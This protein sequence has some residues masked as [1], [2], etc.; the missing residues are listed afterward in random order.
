[1]APKLTQRSAVEYDTILYGNMTPSMAAGYLREGRICSRSFSETLAQMY[2]G[3]DLIQKL[4]DFYMGLG[5]GESLSSTKAKLRNWMTGRHHPG[6]REDYFRIAFALAFSEEQLNLLL[7]IC[8]DY[9]VQY[10]D[11][12]E[13]VLTWFLKRGG[14]YQEALHFLEAVQ[15]PLAEPAS[16]APEASLS[17]DMQ[18]TREI[19]LGLSAVSTIS[20]LR[21]F[22]LKNRGRFGRMHLR[23]YYYFEQYL[24]R[25]IRPDSFVGADEP[26]YTIERVMRTYLSLHMPS[27][28]NRAN[29]SLVQKLIKQ[30]WPNVTSLK[31]ICN[32]EMEVPRKLLL[33]LYVIT[34]N[35][36][37]YDEYQEMDEDYMSMEDRV[38]EHWWTLNAMLADCGMA[39][40]DLRNA[41]DW[42]VLYAVS[43]DDGQPMKE[44]MEGV[45]DELFQDVAAAR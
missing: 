13:A 8:T 1:M 38:E 17:D 25:L 15:K 44:R 42:L 37:F 3:K 30:N 28:R 34:E 21:H 23:S 27:G 22:C 10:R 16:S 18:I 33:L 20:G 11:V 14:T 2:P 31:R 12:R 41:F 26:D 39:S 43:S 7:G 36:G 45:I 24:S 35:I 6:D 5:S 40:L 32:R 4:A 29:Y 9:T 19:H